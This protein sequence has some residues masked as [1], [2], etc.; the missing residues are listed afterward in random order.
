VKGVAS[1]VGRRRLRTKELLH[2]SLSHK[3]EFEKGFSN[4]R[5]GKRFC[6]KLAAGFVVPLMSVVGVAATIIVSPGA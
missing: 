3:R 5:N 1:D 4:S 2:F 6:S